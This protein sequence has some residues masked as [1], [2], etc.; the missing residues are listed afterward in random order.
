LIVLASR[1]WLYSIW[2]TVFSGTLVA[3]GNG[4]TA[5]ATADV[6][7]G[8]PAVVNCPEKDDR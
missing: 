6:L 1:G 2:M 8:D 3:F 5:C 7:V 4:L